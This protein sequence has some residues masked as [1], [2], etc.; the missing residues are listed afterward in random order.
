[1]RKGRAGQ[2]LFKP[3]DLMGGG[4]C[5]KVNKAGNYCAAAH[6]DAYC[7]SRICEHMVTAGS[8]E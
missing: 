7:D 1:M 5:W 8:T 4:R 2:S 6:P 3:C